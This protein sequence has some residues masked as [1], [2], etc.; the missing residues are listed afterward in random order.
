MHTLT[1]F[2]I[3]KKSI[4]KN[5]TILLFSLAAILSSGSLKAQTVQNWK[6]NGNSLTTAGK[7]GTTISQDVNFISNN[8]SRMS[9]K[10]NGNLR[11]NSDQSS[12]LFP[13]PGANPKPMMFIYESGTVNT[14]RMVFAYSPQFPNFGL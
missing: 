4:M 9:L 11:F 6:T 8:V 13:N 12:I 1:F 10:A 14:N 2:I 3:F 5:K 7:L